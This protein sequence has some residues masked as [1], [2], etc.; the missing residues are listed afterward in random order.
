MSRSQSE[1][2]SLERVIR[3]RRSTNRGEPLPRLGDLSDRKALVLMYHRVADDYADPWLY[4]SAPSALLNSSR[5]CEDT[6]SQCRF[7]NWLWLLAAEMF[8]RLA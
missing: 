5:F 4:A 8:R 6:P 2:K 3:L 1:R 7:R